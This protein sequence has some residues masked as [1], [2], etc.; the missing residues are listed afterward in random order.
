MTV[1]R[2]CNRICSGRIYMHWAVL[3]LMSALFHSLTDLFTKKFGDG[4]GTLENA[5][6]QNFFAMPLLWGAAFMEGFPRIDASFPLIIVLAI[7][8]EVT[9]LLMYI[10]SVKISPLSKTVPLLA[11]TPA[12]LLIVAPLM[13]GEKTPLHGMIG[14]G[15]IVAGNYIINIDRKAGLLSPFRTIAGERGSVMMLAVAF[16][17]G[18]TSSFGKMGVVA[19]SALFFAAVYY[20]IAAGVLLLMILV[21]RRARGLLNR[22]LAVV[23]IT[24]SLSLMFHMT[25]LKLTYVSYVISVK[26]TSIVFAI[27][28]GFIFFREKNVSRRVT[29]GAIVLCGI[30]MLVLWK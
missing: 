22:R 4:A 8:V 16:L 20:S 27:I 11:F 28:L 15:I 25:A 3:A 14:V 5:F 6:C 29:G 9:A 17:Y 2:M 7:P 18:I 10:K 30:M 26:R 24:S 1:A 21:K 13:F 12:F 19:S 23:G